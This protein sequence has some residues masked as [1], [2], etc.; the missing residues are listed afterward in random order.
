MKLREVK[1]LCGQVKTIVAAMRQIGVSE[2]TYYRWQ[3]KYGRVTIS[4][5]KKNQELGKENARLKKLAADL[6]LGKR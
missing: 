4:D 6:S 3:K 5:A 2:Q 1:A